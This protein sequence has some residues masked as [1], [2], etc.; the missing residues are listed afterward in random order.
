MNNLSRRTRSD[1][2]RR[3]PPPICR[4]SQSKTHLS[5][6][7]ARHTIIARNSD[8]SPAIIMTKTLKLELLLVASA[9][10][11]FHAASLPISPIPACCLPP[12]PPP[13]FSATPPPLPPP[14]PLFPPPP[15]LPHWPDLHQDTTLRCDGHVRR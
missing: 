4:A 2:P 1:R 6:A 7:C 9:L 11:T 3:P 14:S 8:S 5:P 13:N 10:P 12:P 15:P